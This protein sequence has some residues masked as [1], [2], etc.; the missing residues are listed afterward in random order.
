MVAKLFICFCHS[1]CRLNVETDGSGDCKEGYAP[2]DCCK[3]RSGYSMKNG[4]CGKLQES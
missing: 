2:E 1:E 4:I 3:C